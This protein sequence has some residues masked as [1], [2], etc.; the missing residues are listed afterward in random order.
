MNKEVKQIFLDRL[1]S[2]EFVPLY[3]FLA[4]EMV[5]EQTG[6]SIGLRDVK[7]D[8]NARCCIGVLEECALTA[9]V[10]TEFKSYVQTS[11]PSPET[12][13]WAGITGEQFGKLAELNDEAISQ[14]AEDD[15]AATFDDV[16]EYVE[17]D[18]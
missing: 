10:I 14:A 5:E 3:G 8:S 17:S 6:K 2:G 11:L 4:P 15:E 1:R 9:G 18:L 16:I 13:N 12:V 7:S